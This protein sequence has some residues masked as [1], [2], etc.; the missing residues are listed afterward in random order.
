MVKILSYNIFFKSMINNPLHK[1]C[2]IIHD[3]ENNLDYNSCLKNVSNFIQ[4]NSDFDFV[5]LQEATNWNIIQKITPALQNMKFINHKYDLEEIVT[6]YHVN[7]K[8]DK[9]HNMIKGYMTDKNR[10]FLIL[11]FNNELCLINLHAGHHQDIYHFDNHLIKILEKYHHKN[12]FLD[13][14]K[15]YNIIMAGDFNDNLED[16][17]LK[18]LENKYFGM[19]GGRKLYGFNKIPSCCSYNLDKIYQP[20]SYDHIL[21]TLNN[22]SS[23]VIT[24]KSAS[25]HM[26]I[27]GYVNK[28]IGYDFD[29]VLHIDVSKPDE[30]GQRHPPNLSGPYRPFN[31]IINEI[32]NN[33][34]NGDKI[35]IIT[36]RYNRKQNLDSIMNHL[37]NTKLV[38]YLDNITILFSGGSDKTKLL[39]K[40]KINSF[41]DDSCLRIKELFISR[42][43]GNLPDLTQLYLVYPEK[44][45][46]IKI[47][48][49]N[50]YN[51]CIDNQIAGNIKNIDWNCINE[52]YN[53]I[54]STMN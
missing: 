48:K 39:R 16:N 25:D 50:Y 9:T 19:N 31:K 37:N 33:L 45:S 54:L 11:F 36:A 5:L 53:I 13:K 14:L 40:Y 24:I 30:E 42:I 23:Q 2:K 15:S 51:F 28:N 32:I 47:D 8:L 35:F 26:P 27:I 6:F 18:I 3:P 29:G 43:N 22:I 10:P 38:N 7:Y 49:Q 52:C 44:N 21:S 46:Y 34:N 17:S 12:I 4:D 20:K 41:Y 1:K